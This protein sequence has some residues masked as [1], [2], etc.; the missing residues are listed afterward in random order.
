MKIDQEFVEKANRKLLNADIDGILKWAVETYGSD[1]G[2]TT[3]CSY[4]GV[5]LIYHLRKYY[6]GIELFFFDTGYHFPETVRF[7]KELREKWQLNLKI[8]EPEISHAELIAMVG[9]PPYKTNS[10]QCCYHL[11]I[12]SLLNILPLKKAWLSAIRRDQTPNRANIRPVEIDSRGTLK[13]HPLY[14]RHRAELWDFIHQYKIPYNP[15]YDMNYHSI[16][17]QPCTTAIENPS[18]ER[19]CRWHDSEK[20]ECGLNRY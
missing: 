7:V 1:L 13:I 12:R 10:D 16:G 19:E 14:N 4:N 9:N 15:L 3:T 5:V 2:M 17:C 8:I 18:N 11:K 20:V 6:P